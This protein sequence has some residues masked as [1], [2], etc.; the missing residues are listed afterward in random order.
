MAVASF[1]QDIVLAVAVPLF[2]VVY[3][4]RTIACEEAFLAEKFGPDYLA[5]ARD[6]PMFFPRFAGWR[7][8]GLPFSARNVRK[9]EDSGFF[10]FIATF[11]VI[12]QA[13]ELLV[14]HREAADPVWLATFA[15]G[16]VVYLALRTLKKRTQLLSVQGR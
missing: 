7:T 13:R 9:R 12:D 8:P 5:W 2:L 3:L 6:V 4:E 1:C 14:E 10:A 15:A 16:A 11:F